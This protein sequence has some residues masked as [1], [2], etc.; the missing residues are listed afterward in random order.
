MR[1]RWEPREHSWAWESVTDAKFCSVLLDWPGRV[2]RSR[3]EPSRTDRTPN[4]H[5]WTGRE[6]QGAWEKYAEGTRQIALV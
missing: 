5:R 2:R 3:K 6:Y 4:R 1:N